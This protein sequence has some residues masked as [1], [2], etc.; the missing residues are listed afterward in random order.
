M[1]QAALSLGASHLQAF[2]RVTLPIIKPGVMAGALFAFLT[3]FDEVVVAL[4][5]TGVD[6]VTL[7]VQMWAGIRFEINPV[8]AAVSV[9]LVGLSAF[10]FTVYAL[11][12][13]SQP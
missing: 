10:V 7:P 4:F 1:E 5:M 12:R 8:V 13:R 3:S 11:L 2:L 9:M 6:T